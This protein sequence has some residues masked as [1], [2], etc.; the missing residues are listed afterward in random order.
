MEGTISD[1]T[2]LN[3]AANKP[4]EPQ[5]RRP[6]DGLRA[7]PT[8][9]NEIVSTAPRLT[10][11]QQSSRPAFD[12][13]K[14]RMPKLS[15]SPEVPQRWRHLSIIA[16][17]SLVAVIGFDQQVTPPNVVASDI[18]SSLVTEPSAS[19]GVALVSLP[20]VKSIELPPVPVKKEGI[21]DPYLAAAH[22]ILIDD[23]TKMPLYAKSADEKVAVA[24]TTKLVTAMTAVKYY[25]DLNKVVTISPE[26]A[27]QIGSAVG[28]RVGE[29]ATIEQLLYGLLLVSGNDAA[30][31]LAQQ[32]SDDGSISAFV[33][34]MNET[35]K[36]I[37][38]SN[39]HFA[40]P[41]GLND[42]EGR[43]TAHD[44]ALALGSDLKNKT[45]AK[46]FATHDMAYTT[47]Q[48]IRH[49]L[50]TSNRLMG[51]M[52]INGSEGGKTGYTPHT[53]EGGAGHCLIAAAK[54]NGHRLIVAVLDTDSQA[55][56]ASAE[57]ARDA[58][59][60][61]FTSFDWQSPVR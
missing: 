3:S 38:M 49:D 33:A 59:E 1:Y 10:P 30:Y 36:E 40:D 42:L 24:S 4:L 48:G 37:G 60:Y 55:P 18:S 8:L 13:S 51:E 20:A 27:N 44:M 31:A 54:R 56:Q 58:L 53:T 21:K 11:K 61:G 45:L 41:A 14:W 50:L 29:T 39:S 19:S 46:I 35:A 25:K 15:I 52:L 9:A 34:K 6:G 17:A 47:P 7:R 16:L 23:E 43:A 26:A 12:I 57:V 2:G 5:R 32:M 28:F 22:V